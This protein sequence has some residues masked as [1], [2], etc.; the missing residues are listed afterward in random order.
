VAVTVA[1]DS[2]GR[3]LGR[4]LIETLAVAARERGIETFEMSVL[5]SNRRVRGFLRRIDAECRGRD[6]DVLEYRLPVAAL[7]E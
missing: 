4:R 2:Q 7:L 6:G 5:A 1:D 3:G